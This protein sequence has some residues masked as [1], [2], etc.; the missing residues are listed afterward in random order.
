MNYAPGRL[1][2]VP[3]KNNHAMPILMKVPSE[4]GSNLPGSTSN[5][6]FHIAASVLL[7]EVPGKYCFHS[8]DS[9]TRLMTALRSR[10]RASM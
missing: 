7:C 1:L 9:A 4:D 5:N 3:A 6:D 2:Q 8:E 10:N